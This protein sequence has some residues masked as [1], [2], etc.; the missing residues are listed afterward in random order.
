VVPD[1]SATCATPTN[2]SGAML[3]VRSS[4]STEPTD[5]GRTRWPHRATASDITVRVAHQTCGAGAQSSSSRVQSPAGTRSVDFAAGRSAMSHRVR[6]RL[7][8]Y[9]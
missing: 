9:S 7:R 6:L 4:R 2:A 5:A 3:M 8:F 1:K